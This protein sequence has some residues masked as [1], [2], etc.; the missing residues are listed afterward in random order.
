[1]VPREC[2]A[3]NSTAIQGNGTGSNQGIKNK[4]LRPRRKNEP[5]INSKTTPENTILHF[6]ELR[7]YTVA[8]AVKIDSRL[9]RWLY[10]KASNTTEEERRALAQALGI[11]YIRAA[12]HRKTSAAQF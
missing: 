12:R 11:K 4:G 8:E 10:K 9:C 3:K 2:A 7:G 1:M 6:S 5:M